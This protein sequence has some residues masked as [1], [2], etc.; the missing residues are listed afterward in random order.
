MSRSIKFRAWHKENSEMVYFDNNRVKK[1]QYKACYLASLLAGDFGDVL[2]QYTGLKDKNGVE[3]YE[4]DILNICFTSGSGEFIHDGVYVA[5]TRPLAGIIFRFKS[6]LWSSHGYNQY[7]ISM[8]LSGSNG[9][10]IVYAKDRSYLY[11]KD[12]YKPSVDM[13]RQFP[14]N[15]EKELSFHSRYFEV[16]GNIYENPELL[17]N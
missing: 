2:Q 13:D 6:L 14:F 4:G 3:I 5:E 7:P 1:D 11:A 16:I 10:G 17:E 8:E 9:A 15:E 12:Q